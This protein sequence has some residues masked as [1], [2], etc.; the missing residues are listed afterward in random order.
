MP[1]RLDEHRLIH[2]SGAIP[3][4]NLAVVLQLVFVCERVRH[5]SKTYGGVFY[6]LD[7]L[8]DCRI[9]CITPGVRYCDLFRVSAF[10]TPLVMLDR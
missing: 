9:C 2:I 4:S 6:T 3:M 1:L 10:D 5:L 8:W 7:L